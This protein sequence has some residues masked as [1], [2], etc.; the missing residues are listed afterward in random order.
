MHPLQGALGN[1]QKQHKQPVNHK[2]SLLPQ[3]RRLSKKTSSSVEPA[4][5]HSSPAVES[6]SSSDL[7]GSSE[8]TDG[9]SSAQEEPF[10]SCIDT[11]RC[12]WPCTGDS[13]VI[14]KRVFGSERLISSPAVSGLLRTES[15]IGAME[16]AQSYECNLSKP[17]ESAPQ[18]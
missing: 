8:G 3:V 5:I 1:L 4:R 18:L 14:L 2:H 12:V 9:T 15:S 11:L 6:G 10:F 17:S 13:I 16:S 7:R